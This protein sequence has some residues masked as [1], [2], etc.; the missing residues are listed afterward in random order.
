LIA[1]FD[2][3]DAT[4]IVEGVH[5]EQWS[6]L[7]VAEHFLRRIQRYEADLQTGSSDFIKFW[8]TFG[9]PQANISLPREAG[10]LPVGLQVIGAFRSDAVVL[11]LVERIAEVLNGGVPLHP[12]TFS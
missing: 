1:E 6:V 9:L 3:V 11:K 2:T 8:T 12:Q 7:D 4:A 10:A 5:L